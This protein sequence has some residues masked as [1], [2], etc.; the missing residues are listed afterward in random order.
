MDQVRAGFFGAQAQRIQRGRDEVR[1]WVRYKE[2]ERSS[3]SQLGDMRIRTNNGGAYPLS[4]IARMEIKRGVMSINHKDFRREVTVEAD[5][6]DDKVSVTAILADIKD[7]V[8]PAIQKKYPD[9]EFFFEGQSRDS[10]QTTDAAMAIVPALM[11]LMFVVT[12]YT[13]RSFA[14]AL[15]V[16][17]LIPFSFIGVA[18]GHLVQGY[19]VS[20]LSM[21][22]II[23]LIGIIVNDSLVLISA[24]NRNLKDGME[25]KEALFL[26]GTSRFRAV[27]LTSITT[28]AGLGPLMFESSFQAQFLSPMAISVAY[29]LFLATLLTLIMLPA[30]LVVFNNIKGFLY[31]LWNGK[32]IEARLLEAAVIE[33]KK[34]GMFE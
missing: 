20:L 6:R 2:E 9:I 11:L 34:A 31:W 21:F 10:K 18:W 24:M 1:I 13:F 17:I 29:G 30:L 19:P 14:Q 7:N 25:F 32:R 12:A 5:V 3:I 16:F 23:A 15:L 27:F 22:G 4:E 28:I 8:L 26:A 33:D